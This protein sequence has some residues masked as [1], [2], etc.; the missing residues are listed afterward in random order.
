MLLSLLLQDDNDADYATVIRA[1]TN[2]NNQWRDTRIE[3]NIHKKKQIMQS[4]GKVFS[5]LVVEELLELLEL[6]RIDILFYQEK[7]IWLNR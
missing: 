1:C 6:D 2:I 3:S 5:L 7:K 4:I